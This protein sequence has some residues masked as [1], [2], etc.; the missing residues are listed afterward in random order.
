MRLAIISDLHL[1]EPPGFWA[2]TTG[3]H[4]LAHGIRAKRLV[5][6]ILQLPGS[7]QV[8]VLGD[9]T[10]R[11]TDRELDEMLEVLAE[12]PRERLDIVPGNHDTTSALRMGMGYSA[13]RHDA[14][15]DTVEQLTGRSVYPYARDFGAWRLLCLDSAAHHESGTLFARGRIGHR[16]LAWLASELADQRPTIIALH[17][18]PA[19]VNPTLAIDDA[20]EFLAVCARQH[21]TVINGHRH[22]PGVYPRT[23]DRPRIIASGKSVETMRVRLLDPVS[24]GWRWIH[25]P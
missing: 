8:V 25:V 21:V 11:T 24:G 19:P 6:K 10:D 12:I 3:R 22:L 15:R 9:V 20:D 13:R 23:H 2:R 5:D 16:Q 7:P 4:D 1:G 14:F 18:Y 17:H